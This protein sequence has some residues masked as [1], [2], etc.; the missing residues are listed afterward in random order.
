M[1]TSVQ[2]SVASSMTI[3]SPSEMQFFEYSIRS[4]MPSFFMGRG[5]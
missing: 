5:R 2:A 4:G 1:L 3:I